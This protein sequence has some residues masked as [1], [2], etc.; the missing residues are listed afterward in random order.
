MEKQASI[1]NATIMLILTIILV[2]IMLA[3]FFSQADTFL[4]LLKGE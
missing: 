2:I 1:S 4:T 3:I